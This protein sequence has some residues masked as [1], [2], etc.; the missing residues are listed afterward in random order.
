MRTGTKPGRQ[1]AT[2]PGPRQVPRFGQHCAEGLS[3]ALSSTSRLPKLSWHSPSALWLCPAAVT[4]Q[5]AGAGCAGTKGERN[6]PPCQR[7]C[8]RW[9]GAFPLTSVNPRKYRPIL[10]IQNRKREHKWLSQGHTGHAGG[11]GSACPPGPHVVSRCPPPSTWPRPLSWPPVP[12]PGGLQGLIC[13]HSLEPTSAGEGGRALATGLSGGKQPPFGFLNTRCCVRSPRVGSGQRLL[14]EFIPR[15][16]GHEAVTTAAASDSPRENKYRMTTAC[17]E[18]AGAAG[19]GCVREEDFH[20]LVAERARP[21]LPSSVG[22]EG[23]DR[24]RVQTRALRSPQAEPPHSC[25]SRRP[26]RHSR[27]VSAEITGRAGVPLGR[28][29][30]QLPLRSGGFWRGPERQGWCEGG[31]RGPHKGQREVRRGRNW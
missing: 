20:Q 26:S 6:G 19:A 18:G 23:G 22:G 31:R 17:L 11:P 27:S 13:F 9:A 24:C 30:S 3:L 10:Q 5:H 8:A 25:G 29:S 1:T 28:A 21:G 15:L 7:P 14:V 16:H 2:V 12:F 4:A